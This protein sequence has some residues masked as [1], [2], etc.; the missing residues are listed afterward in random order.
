MPPPMW[1]KIRLW[2]R[3]RKAL[4]LAATSTTVDVRV[5]QADRVS[6]MPDIFRGV[7]I[8]NVRQADRHLLEA[9]A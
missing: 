9:A 7:P 8:A 4:V 6:G 1:I 3:Y 2:G 5:N